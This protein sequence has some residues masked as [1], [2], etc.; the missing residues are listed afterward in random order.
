M[1]TQRR[2]VIVGGGFGGLAAAKRLRPVPVQV[3]LLDRRNYHLFQP[4]LYQVA[5]GV[6]SPANIASPLRGILRHQRN[7]QVLMNEVVD[8]D[9]VGRKVL[10]REGDPISYDWLIVAGGATHGYFGRDEWAQYAPGL[11]TIEDATEIRK[12]ILFAFEAAEQELDP[13]RRRAWLTFV[14]VGGGPTGVEMAGAL[15]DI[16]HYTLRHDFRNIRSSEARIVLVEASQYPLDMYG[17]DLPARSLDAL[18][19]LHVE[20]RT[21]TK[22]VDIQDHHVVLESAGQ[23][24]TLETETVVW[25]AG[26]KASP[27]AA[28]LANACGL[29]TDRAGRI[30]VGSDLTIAGHAEVMVIGDMASCSNEGK[31]LPGLAP[32]AMQQGQYCA[33]RIEAHLAG[34]ST[35][36]FQYRD[37]GSMAVIGRY[38]AVAQ[39]GKR[40]FFGLLAW[41]MWLVIHILE[42]TQFRNRLLVLVQWGWTFFTRDRAARLITGQTEP[43]VVS[44]R[45]DGDSRSPGTP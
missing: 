37:R 30:P 5:T 11:K 24:A 8:F 27:L 29:T 2:V 13:N 3:T 21:L 39:I 26:V 16:A 1:S 10:V 31:P 35:Q 17:G 28:K 44:A 14:I 33:Q 25:A 19:K 7:C 23:R 41:A 6:L 45:S 4:L 40:R 43:R 9:L 12:R 20:V 18:Y 15:S 42:I 34:R 36:Q 22:V 32:V 38:R